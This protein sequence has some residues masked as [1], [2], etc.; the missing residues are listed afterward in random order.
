MYFA[1]TKTTFHMKRVA[2]HSFCTYITWR[3]NKNCWFCYQQQ[4]GKLHDAYNFYGWPGKMCI[5]NSKQSEKQNTRTSVVKVGVFQIV[6]IET[7]VHSARHNTLQH[8]EQKC[9]WEKVRENL[10]WPAFDPRMRHSLHRK[11]VVCSQ[12]RALCY[13]LLF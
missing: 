5:R 7:G 2:L 4:G 11:Q 10:E 9:A 13:R 1:L 3:H 12:H 6:T 8:P